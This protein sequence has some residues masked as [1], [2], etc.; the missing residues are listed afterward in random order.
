M[1][2]L[3]FSLGMLSA[4]A[5]L[6]VLLPW[7]KS[8]PNLQSLPSLPWPVPLAGALILIG[9]VSMYRWLGHPEL[10]AAG[11]TPALPAAA[12]GAAGSSN[13][14]A[15]SM[16]SALASLEGRLAK[17]GGSDGDWELL[18]KT[19]EFLGRTDDAAKARS[20]ILNPNGV[21]DVPAAKSPAPVLSEESLKL[22]AKASRARTDKE[23][24]ASVKIYAEL[25]A[26]RQLNADGWADYADAAA[27]L[28]NGK[29]AGEPRS[30]IDNAL[31][32]DPNHPKALWLKASAEEEAG[33]LSAAMRSWQRLQ[34]VLPPD[35][36]DAKIVAANSKRDADV[37]R[38]DTVP[39]ALP[40]TLA[41]GIAVTGD[42]TLAGSL[43]GKSARG[44]G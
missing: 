33:E 24:S 22:L 41:Q 6:C 3:W 27:T 23:Y 40:A 17:S 34:G 44:R 25:A 38:A 30:Y 42:V 15:G 36:E 35:S 5:I 13:A 14:A 2:V 7:L 10:T 18:A 29:L 11:A 26:R 39:K 31:A 37:V 21:A 19:Y 28:Q 12:M 32:I 43:E 4:V 1:P 8:I 16:Q 20:H 9:A